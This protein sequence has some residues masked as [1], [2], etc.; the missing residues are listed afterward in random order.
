[1]RVFGSFAALALVALTSASPRVVYADEPS[2][3]G[4]IIEGGYAGF[5]GGLQ[6][7]TGRALLG[8]EL[9]SEALHI[10]LRVHAG[11]IFTAAP[12]PVVGL[13]LQAST[14][15]SAPVGFRF[16]FG[17]ELLVPTTSSGIVRVAL[18]IDVAPRFQ[19]GGDWFAELPLSIGWAPGGERDVVG[20]RVGPGIERALVAAQ[21]G[22]SLSRIGVSSG[23]VFGASLALGRRF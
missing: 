2:S 11:A 13:R 9:R 15:W 14:G 16:A 12:M 20:L 1:M 10:G 8:Y 22:A 17:P 21:S 6:G 18:V 3:H 4:V 5:G 23:V 19:L 7:H